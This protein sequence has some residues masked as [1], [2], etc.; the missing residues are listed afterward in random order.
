MSKKKIDS[1]QN[2]WL[3][4]GI[5]A[6][7]AIAAIVVMSMGVSKLSLTSGQTVIISEDDLA[8]QASRKTVTDSYTTI[9]KKVGTDCN[10]ESNAKKPKDF[11]GC[12]LTD[13]G[14][15]NDICGKSWDNSYYCYKKG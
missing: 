3:Y 6:I 13:K 14:A 9:C 11:L 2:N 7:V 4:L 5:V 8:G 12:I 15:C 10:Y 1:K